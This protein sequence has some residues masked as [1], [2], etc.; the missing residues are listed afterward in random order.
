[1]IIYSIC[2]YNL[3]YYYIFK[4]KF[5]NYHQLVYPWLFIKAIILIGEMFYVLKNYCMN[6]CKPTT[7]QLVVLGMSI[8][9]EEIFLS[10]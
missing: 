9:I 6:D 10:L 5:Q 1:M 2:G 7:L 4:S 8:V 3:K